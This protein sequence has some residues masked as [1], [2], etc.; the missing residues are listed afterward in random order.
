MPSLVA[1]S[2]VAPHRGHPFAEHKHSSVARTPDHPQQPFID[3]T[4]CANVLVP[5][6]VGMIAGEHQAQ[7]S[8]RSQGA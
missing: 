5:Q 8:K 3:A 1:P 7:S 4:S 6:I 2:F